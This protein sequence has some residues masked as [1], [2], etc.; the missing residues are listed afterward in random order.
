MKN[1]LVVVNTASGGIAPRIRIE[2]SIQAKL[3]RFLA[4]DL[5][6]FRV[7]RVKCVIA[8][9]DVSQSEPIVRQLYKNGYDSFLG[10]MLAFLT[11]WH[12][13]RRINRPLYWAN[14]EGLRLIAEYGDPHKA[15]A[16]LM[17]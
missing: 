4:R 7:N 9:Y 16:S 12:F 6:E 8:E 11:G 14:S 10:A 2:A 5:N 1:N 3:D 15:Y 17:N 13:I